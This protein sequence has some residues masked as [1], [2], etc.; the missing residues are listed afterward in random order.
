LLA[1]S[2]VIA[3]V[4]GLALQSTLSEVFSG[5]V[6]GIERPYQPGDLLWVEGDVE[7]YVV[8]VNWRSTHIAT[9]QHNI[10]IVPNSIIAKSRLVNR[11]APTPLRAT[12]SWS[13][14]MS[15]PCR[16][17]VSPPSKPPRARAA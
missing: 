9:A 6:V 2:G 7:G 12:R 17:I 4:L 11:S 10:A 3:I 1:T 8:Q 5:I 13:T 15:G 16:R 14:S